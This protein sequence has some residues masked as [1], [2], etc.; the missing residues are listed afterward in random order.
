MTAFATTAGDRTIAAL[1]RLGHGCL[2]AALL[3]A[4]SGVFLALVPAAVED[5]RYSYPLSAGWFAVIQAWFA[6][7]HLGLL[8]GI[9]G[10]DRSGVAG[11]H[12]LGLA[13]AAGGMALLAVVELLAI[14]AARSPYPDGVRT[15]ALDG[16]YGVSTVAIGVGLTA[17][18]VAI[19]R[20]GVWRG[21]RRWV[22]LATGLYV[23]VPMFPAMFGSFLAARLAITGWM[24][25]FALLGWSLAR[26]GAR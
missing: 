1:G 25:L 7:Q 5:D 10:L 15:D 20:A 16:L 11:R 6:V 2:W 23:F 26:W 21:W 18:G 14:S 22:P 4:A 3:G 12:R 19:A 9:A 13:I 24:L 17:A 8:G